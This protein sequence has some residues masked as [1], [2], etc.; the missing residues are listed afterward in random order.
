MRRLPGGE[1]F[2]PRNERG[3]MSMP[4][5]E[6]YAD[7]PNV[8]TSKPL[9]LK[10]EVVENNENGIKMKVKSAALAAV[11]KR[12]LGIQEHRERGVML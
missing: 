4:L 5:S 3:I 6:I 12:N 2:I 11:P 9:V 7:V 10:V 8:E 1:F